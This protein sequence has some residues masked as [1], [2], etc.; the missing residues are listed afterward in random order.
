MRYSILTSPLPEE[1]KVNGEK[2]KIH[3]DFR[4]WIQFNYILE[5]KELSV[6]QKFAKVCKNCLEEF[7]DTDN[8]PEL[9]SS[10]SEF[11]K[12]ISSYE[13]SNAENN[14]TGKAIYDY[15]EDQK[16]IYSSF[17]AFYGIDLTTAHIHWWKFKALFEGLG[18]DT[19]IMKIIS[20]RSIDISKIK[21][22]EQKAFYRKMKQRYALPDNRTEEEKEQAMNNMLAMMF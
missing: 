14:G 1:V 7:P 20:Y 12:G 15:T 9:L 4:I 17:Y 13:K 21:D 11:A 8:L 5:D 2:F 3:T 6:P 10:L 18:E 19:E 22:K 16:A